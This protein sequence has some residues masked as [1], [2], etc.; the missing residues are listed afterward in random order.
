VLMDWV[1]K[2]ARK[3]TIETDYSI[4]CPSTRLVFHL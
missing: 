2:T 4:V 1:Y 3:A